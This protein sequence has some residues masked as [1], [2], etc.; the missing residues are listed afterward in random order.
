[1]RELRDLQAARASLVRARV[2]IRSRQG[3]ARLPL[4]RRLAARSLREADRQLDELDA[5]IERRIGADPDFAERRRILLPVPG[6][7][8]LVTATLVAR[9]PEPGGSSA[10]ESAAL[11]GL[12]PMTRQS[13]RWCG[14]ARISGGRRAVG[15]ALHMPALSAIRHHPDM[16]RTYERLCAVGKPPKV[17]ITAVMRKLVVLANT[18]LAEGRAWQ[19]RPA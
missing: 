13:G 18:V 1:M 11:A 3:Q 5:E 4:L 6:F 15:Q 8:P 2:A 9:M 7:G 14:K 17:A 12:A 19:P 16:R 10:K